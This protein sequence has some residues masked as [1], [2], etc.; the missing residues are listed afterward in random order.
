M[1]LFKKKFDLESSFPYLN[2]ALHMFLR[3]PVSNRST[4]RSFSVLKRVKNCLR[5]TMSSDRLN[6]LAV[7]AIESSVINELDFSEIIKTFVQA[8]RKKL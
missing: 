1:S 8:R 3:T 2:V 6:S 7:L 5:S 4:E